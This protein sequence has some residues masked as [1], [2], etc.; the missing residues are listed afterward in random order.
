MKSPLNLLV[1]SRIV[2]LELMSHQLPKKLFE[3]LSVMRNYFPFLYARSCYTDRND[4]GVTHYQPKPLCRL[5]LA[6]S[7]W[8][9]IHL[10]FRAS[11][12]LH[13]VNKEE[14]RAGTGCGISIYSLSSSCAERSLCVRLFLLLLMVY[15]EAKWKYSW[16]CEMLCCC[17]SRQ[18]SSSTSIIVL[19]WLR[20]GSIW[21]SREHHRGNF[22]NNSSRNWF[23]CIS[24]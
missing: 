7:S 2:S 3:K 24:L 21:F 16:N 11:R 8:R 10:H 9:N 18:L 23:D 4:D 12:S 22:M 13:D 5:W 14:M 1:N 17:C 6:R 20:S 19:F 15:Y